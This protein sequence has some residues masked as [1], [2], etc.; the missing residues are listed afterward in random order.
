MKRTFLLVPAAFALCVFSAFI[1]L[2]LQTVRSL[3]RLGIP[4]T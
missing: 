3:E 1:F 4:R 2:E